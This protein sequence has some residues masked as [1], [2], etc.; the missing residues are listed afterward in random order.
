MIDMPGG[1]LL[2]KGISSVTIHLRN[3]FTQNSRQRILGALPEH[4][5]FIA[6]SYA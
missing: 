1:S 2:T 4:T 5:L 6:E 3:A